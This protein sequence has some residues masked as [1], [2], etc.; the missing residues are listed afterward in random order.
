MRKTAQ[1]I[2][3]IGFAFIFTANVQGLEPGQKEP[4]SHYI[5]GDSISLGF[6]ALFIG[7]NPLQSWVS[8]NGV[9]VNS[10]KQRLDNRYGN[11]RVTHNASFTGNS[12][13][14]GFSYDI[15]S[16]RAL[17]SSA[18]YITIQLGA[19]DICALGDW[20]GIENLPSADSIYDSTYDGIHTLLDLVEPGTTIEFIA[21][22]DVSRIY[23]V[24]QNKRALGIVRCPIVWNVVNAVVPDLLCPSVTD[25][26]LT[27]EQRAQVKQLNIE[28]N[29]AISDAIN[30]A[31]QEIAADESLPNVFISLND[32]SFFDFDKKHTSTWDC[33][34]PSVAGQRELAKRVSE[35]GPFY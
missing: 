12:L 17:V 6:M 1:L 22:P 27:D 9:G 34:H 20:N 23:E 7:A 8:G 19:N 3:I 32:A 21:I 24:G 10:I 16:D 4:L 11:N 28:Y 14:A 5:F 29:T 26:S 31:Q 2:S 13:A 15:R 30:L 35:N 33:F 18:D 25:Q